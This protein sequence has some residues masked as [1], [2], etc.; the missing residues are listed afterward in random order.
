MILVM[1]NLRLEKLSGIT[2][3]NNSCFL[4]ENIRVIG[5]TGI[6]D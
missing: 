4:R 6:F 5:L 2:T 3:G 1:E